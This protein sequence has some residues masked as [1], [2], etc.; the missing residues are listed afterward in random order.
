MR[1]RFEKLGSSAFKRCITRP[2][3]TNCRTFLGTDSNV[4]QKWKMPIMARLNYIPTARRKSWKILA[5]AIIGLKWGWEISWRL[6]CFVLLFRGKSILKVRK[7]WINFLKENAQF[8]ELPLVQKHKT[9]CW[10]LDQCKSTLRLPCSVKRFIH[11]TQERTPRIQTTI[12]R[13][14]LLT[15]NWVVF[16]FCQK[17]GSSFCKKIKRKHISANIRLFLTLRS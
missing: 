2:N 1:Y 10:P 9:L 5:R 12:T 13:K 17:F 16:S 8:C 3:W 6:L 11:R 15:S 7:T 14:G 4:S